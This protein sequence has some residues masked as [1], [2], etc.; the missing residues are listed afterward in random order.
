[1][2]F[3]EKIL[4]N[5]FRLFVVLSIL[6]HLFLMALLAVRWPK[7]GQ[8]IPALMNVSR[9]LIPPTFRFRSKRKRSC[10]RSPKIFPKAIL[11][12]RRPAQWLRACFLTEPPIAKPWVQPK[13]ASKSSPSKLLNSRGES[14]ISTRQLR[15][16]LLRPP[17]RHQRQRHSRRKPPPPN[18]TLLQLRRSL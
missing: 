13:A 7:T 8:T 11:L 12:Y 16:H 5:P 1:M 2:A 17:R 6:F 18:R 4:Q 3:Q 10:R 9:G 14:P 15:R